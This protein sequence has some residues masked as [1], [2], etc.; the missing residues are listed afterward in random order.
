MLD[1]K[2]AERT[3]AHHRRS[4]KSEQDLQQDF[5]LL[6]RHFIFIDPST[7]ADRQWMEELKQKNLVIELHTASDTVTRISTWKWHA[8]LKQTVLSVPGAH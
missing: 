8:V 5:Q 6:N 2:T 3:C 1:A 7:E 4:P